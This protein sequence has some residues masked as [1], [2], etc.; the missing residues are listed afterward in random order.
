MTTIAQRFGSRATNPENSKKELLTEKS[1]FGT[2]EMCS[3]KTSIS[4][5]T[6]TS[7]KQIQTKILIHSGECMINLARAFLLH[8]ETL[9]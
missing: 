6:N 1:P 2:N 8:F 9:A 7:E 5:E 4:G 3:E